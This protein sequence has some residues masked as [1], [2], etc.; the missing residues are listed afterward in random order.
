MTK[1]R[2]LRERLQAQGGHETMDAQYKQPDTEA[3]KVAPREAADA[4]S[5]ITPTISTLVRHR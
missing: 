2:H 4:P 5:R 3:G 1:L